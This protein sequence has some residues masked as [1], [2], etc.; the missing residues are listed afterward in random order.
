M[1]CNTTQQC[2]D[3]RI[4]TTK[5]EVGFESEATRLVREPNPQILVNLVLS[6]KV[7]FSLV[8]GS[9]G[10]AYQESGGCQLITFGQILILTPSCPTRP[11]RGNLEISYRSMVLIHI[12]CIKFV[13][14]D[15]Y[16]HN[17]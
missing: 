2:P 9:L 6:D 5:S 16:S 12:K 10:V 13:K 8:S 4:H 15:I 1:F 7:F 11:N 17:A 14:S 3:K